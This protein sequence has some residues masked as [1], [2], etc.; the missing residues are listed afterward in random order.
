MALAAVLSAMRSIIL[1]APK[2][3]VDETARRS[4]Y[5]EQFPELSDFEVADLAKMQPNRLAIYTR[6]IFTGEAGILKNFFRMTIAVIERAQQRRSQPLKL[7]DAVQRMHSLFP[8]KT[9]TTEGLVESFE[10]FLAHEAFEL[11]EQRELIREIAAFERHIFYARRLPW[12]ERSPDTHFRIE[13]LHSLTV[14]EVLSM[15]YALPTTT[16]FGTFHWDI[17]AAH[18]AFKRDGVLPEQ[19]E[20]R[21]LHLVFSRDSA[22]YIHWTK[23]PES[24][25]AHLSSGD[26]T[27]RALG[28]LAETFVASYPAGSDEA[29]MF[30]DFL[31]LIDTLVSSGAIV[32]RG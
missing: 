2:L 16:S 32:L 1:D 26:D 12:D 30:S 9:K 17:P 21:A 4:F 8:W 6:S 15:N 13:R 14:G 7:R 18:A 27:N 23:V 20:A 25:F 19:L 24:V 11:G 28:D 31:K 5:R 29:Q 22:H 10:R 3:P